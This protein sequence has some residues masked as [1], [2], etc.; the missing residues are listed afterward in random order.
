[1]CPCPCFLS[2]SRLIVPIFLF[3]FWA[4]EISSGAICRA[5][6][7]RDSISA[8]TG[9][10]KLTIYLAIQFVFLIKSAV[11]TRRWAHSRNTFGSISEI[12]TTKRKTAQHGEF[13]KW[14]DKIVWQFRI[15]VH[16]GRVW[17][18]NFLKPRGLSIGTPG[19][20]FAE[21]LSRKTYRRKCV[22]SSQRVISI[23]PEQD[24]RRQWCNENR[25]LSREWVLRV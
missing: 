17:S 10:I 4:G 21:N 3:S 5:L 20:F 14:C 2:V 1:M 25:A 7:G 16:H 6:V 9:R 13:S 22:K 23:A 24:V 18:R 11:S 19:W 12:K 8:S 15:E